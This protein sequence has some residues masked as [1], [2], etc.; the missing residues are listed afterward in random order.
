MTGHAQSILWERC[1]GIS[2]TFGLYQLRHAKTRTR[3]YLTGQPNN[4]I[5]KVP[6][7]SDAKGPPS[8]R[9][10]FGLSLPS[11]IFKPQPRVHRLLTS[12]RQAR[13]AGKKHKVHRH[14]IYYFE[15]YTPVT[16]LEPLHQ[17][18]Q[19]SRLCLAF[20]AHASTCVVE[21]TRQK[22]F[23]PPMLQ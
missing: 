22:L 2:R 18:S 3:P 13:R 14:I 12:P 15:V 19:P 4:Q 20:A 9:R 1:S 21:N 16:A 11:T 7:C 6:E 8:L 23:T 5:S 17:I 10:P